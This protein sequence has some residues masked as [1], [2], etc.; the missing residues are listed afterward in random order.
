VLTAKPVQIKQ[1]LAGCLSLDEECISGELRTPTP[2]LIEDVQLRFS[3]K[4]ASRDP[5]IC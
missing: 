4:P 1:T 2:K 3:D 5:G